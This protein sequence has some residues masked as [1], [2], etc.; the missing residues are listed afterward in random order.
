MR[1]LIGPLRSQRWLLIPIALSE[2]GRKYNAYITLM[3]AM[4]VI[5]RNQFLAE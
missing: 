2:I 4:V 5:A 1:S 3:T